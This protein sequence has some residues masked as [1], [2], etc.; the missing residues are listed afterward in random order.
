MIAMNDHRHV[1]IGARDKLIAKQFEPGSY[2][3]IYFV[4]PTVV[5]I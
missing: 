1:S 5:A 3:L 2:L 4:L